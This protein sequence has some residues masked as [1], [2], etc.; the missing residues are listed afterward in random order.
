MA[1][2]EAKQAELQQQLGAAQQEIAKLRSEVEEIDRRR[3]EAV[4]YAEIVVRLRNSLR[5]LHDVLHQAVLA[6][7][8]ECERENGSKS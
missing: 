7:C 1:A 8:T 4:H 3:S 5:Y 2:A 6:D